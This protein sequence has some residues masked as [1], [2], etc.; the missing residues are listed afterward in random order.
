M[1]IL[2]WD[3]SYSSISLSYSYVPLTPA[4]PLLFSL[5]TLPTSYICRAPTGR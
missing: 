3:Y 2:Y 1:Y 5:L 4:N